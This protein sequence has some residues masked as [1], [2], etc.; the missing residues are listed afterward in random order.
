MA[1]CRDKELTGKFHCFIV[2]SFGNQKLKNYRD[3][4]FKMTI[5]GQTLWMHLRPNLSLHQPQQGKLQEPENGNNC[6]YDFSLCT[7]L[8]SKV[9]SSIEQQQVPPLV[10]V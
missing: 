5:L 2:N 8:G 7:E 3:F 9:D 10:E 6:Y 1:Q 4:L